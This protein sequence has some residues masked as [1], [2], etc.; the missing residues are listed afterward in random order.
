LRGDEY[1]KR[2]TIFL[3]KYKLIEDHNKKFE[4]GLVSYSLAINEV[5]HFEH[6]ELVRM[7]T[8]YVEPSVNETKSIKY[9]KMPEAAVTLPSSFDW[10]YTP[11]VGVVQPVQNQ[12]KLLIVNNYIH[13]ILFV[14]KSVLL[15]FLLGIC[16]NCSNGRTN[17]IK[18]QPARQ[19]F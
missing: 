17:G 19:T 9:A 5:S 4:K 15:W 14:T 16:W 12:V 7:R 18:G 6:H 13:Y 3:R 1:E 2:K 10:R 11:R 8:G